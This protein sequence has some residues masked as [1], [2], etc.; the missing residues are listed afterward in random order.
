VLCKD[1]PAF[2]GNRIGVYSM[3]A[4]SHLVEKMDL[5][6]E[7]IDKYTGPAMG[8]PKSATFRTADVVGLDTLVNVA[9]GLYENV[10]DDEARE[11]FALPEYIKKMVEHKW[12]GEKSGQGFYKKVKGEGGKSEILSLD[13]KSLEYGAQR[14]VKSSTL[15]ATK[16]VDDLRK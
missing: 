10:P 3:L 8:H 11:V 2:I 14:K 12:L 4:L 13:L 15:E 1:T 16:P 9:N 5:S 6:V 7:E